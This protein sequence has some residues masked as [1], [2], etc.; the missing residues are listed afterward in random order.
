[1]YLKCHSSSYV[2]V[3]KGHIFNACLQVRGWERLGC[4]AKRLAGVVPEVNLR[5]P[6]HAGDKTCKQGGPPWLWNQGQM[7]PEVQNRGISGPTK[8]TDVLQNF[9]KNKKDTYSLVIYS[10]KSSKKVDAAM[11]GIVP[12][13]WK[14]SELFCRIFDSND[15]ALAMALGSTITSLASK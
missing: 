8:R 4:H 5:I 2:H 11:C 15:K 6:L 14:Y 9:L 12:Y 13:F 1:M 7:S 3:T 10:I